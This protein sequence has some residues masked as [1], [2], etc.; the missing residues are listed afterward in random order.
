M[1]NKQVRLNELPAFINKLVQAGMIITR[2][3]KNGNGTRDYVYVE[4]CD[5]AMM[6]NIARRVLHTDDRNKVYSKK[7]L[8][9]V[10]EK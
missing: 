1:Q 9:K 4:Y 6:V 10:D 5:Q 8:L 3:V 2:C 7:N